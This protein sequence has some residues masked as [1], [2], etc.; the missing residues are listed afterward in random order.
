MR[1]TTTVL[2]ALIAGM[3]LLT[4]ACSGDGDGDG[5]ADDGAT[6]STPIA[7][8]GALSTDA[9]DGRTFLSTS[10]E[11]PTPP[12]DG[13]RLRLSFDGDQLSFQAGCNTYGGTYALDDDALRAGPLAGTEMGCPDGLH[14][15]D[16]SLADLFQGGVTAQLDGAELTL[17]SGATTIE[18][19]DEQEAVPDQPLVGTTWTLTTIVTG[20][21]PDGAASSVPAGVEPPTLLVAEDGT[22]TLFDGCLASTTTVE[23]GATSLTFGPVDPTDQACDGSTE[24]MGVLDAVHAVVAEGETTYQLDGDTLSLTRGDRGLVLTAD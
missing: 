12:V 13:T 1:R 22:A 5:G 18:L 20:T 8:D 16:E 21:G 9:L 24:L 4:T 19:L 14:E 11:A 6:T 17:T 3:A 15:Q 23:V 10:W 2:L 7:D